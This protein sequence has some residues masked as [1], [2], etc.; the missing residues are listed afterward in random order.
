MAAAGLADLG[1]V[2]DRGADPALNGNALGEAPGGVIVRSS[3][4]TANTRDPFSC[5]SRASISRRLSGSYAG[6]WVTV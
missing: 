4:T 5:F 2:G 3:S 1:A 6:N